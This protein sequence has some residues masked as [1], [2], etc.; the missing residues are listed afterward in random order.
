MD[1]L[2]FSGGYRDEAGY[3]AITWRVEGSRRYKLPSLDVFTTVRGIGLRGGDFDGLEP[4]DPPAVAGSCRSTRPGSSPAA[5]FP[6][7][8]PAP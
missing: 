7:T 4:V 2:I 1:T 5:C 3:E 8:C 6:V